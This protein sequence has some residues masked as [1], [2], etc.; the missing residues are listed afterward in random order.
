MATIDGGIAA[1]AAAQLLTARRWRQRGGI[2]LRYAAVALGSGLLLVSVSAGQVAGVPTQLRALLAAGAL[3]SGLA[4]LVAAAC[5]VRPPA[6]WRALYTRLRSVALAGVLALCLDGLVTLGAMVFLMV[7]L[8]PAAAYPTDAV[9]YTHIDA[10]LALAGQDPYTRA[11]T[12]AQALRRFPSAP[13]TP[14]RRGS[15]AGSSDFPDGSRV[16]ALERQYLAAPRSLRGELDSQLVHSYPAL[17]FLLYV[18]MLW[19]GLGN[20]LLLHVLVYVGLLVWLVWEAPASARGWATLVAASAMAVQA[21]SLRADT[22]VV[23]V[24]LLLGAWHYRERSWL[25]AALL[26]LACAFKQYCWLFVPF[27]AVESLLTRGRRATLQSGALALAIFLLPNLPYMI[28][29]PGA[30]FQSIWLPVTEPFFPYGDGLVTLS[31]GHLAP[32]MPPIVYALLEAAWLV[33]VLWSAARWRVWV[34]EAMLVLALVTLFFAFRS[35][36]NYFA[37]APW[38][39]LYAANRLYARSEPVSAPAAAPGYA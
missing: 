19:A 23:C 20:I 13:A 5:A 38:L 11:G 1:G 35:L 16:L 36:A 24:A 26:G 4:C 34:G 9:A 33:G 17:S 31:I 6:G 3:A 27:F 18:P 14:L 21:Y 10:Q 7:A 29:S 28:A 30:W 2:P 32:Y 37:F 12:L 39:A 15:L 22:E 8:P 25:G